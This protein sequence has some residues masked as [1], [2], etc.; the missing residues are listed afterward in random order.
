MATPSAPIQVAI[1]KALSKIGA[2]NGTALNEMTAP[3]GLT[4]EEAD[5]WH[6]ERQMWF[7]LMVMQQMEAYASKNVDA[8]KD[9][10]IKRFPK[11]KDTKAGTSYGVTRG[12]VSGTVEVRN[13]RAILDG[14]LLV[15]ALAKRGTDLAEVEKIVAESTK[16]S[17]P[18]KYFK[19][20]I[21]TDQG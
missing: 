19:V 18:G 3:P 14:A 12:N 5:A 11:I 17:A 16:T 2:T 6:D 4:N 1:A 15:S 13:G 9:Q 21:I 10:I 7:N 20:S 8:F